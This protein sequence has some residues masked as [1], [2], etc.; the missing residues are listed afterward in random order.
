MRARSWASRSLACYTQHAAQVYH[1]DI[2]REFF[3]PFW[4]VPL[5]ICERNV[6][7]LNVHSRRGLVIAVFKTNDVKVPAMPTMIYEALLPV[8]FIFPQLFRLV[9]GRDQIKP[10]FL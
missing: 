6:P 4:R 5:P 10:F 3:T 2:T 9:A 7:K 8:W 1:Y